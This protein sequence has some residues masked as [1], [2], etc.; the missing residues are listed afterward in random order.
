MTKYYSPSESGFYDSGIH[1]D[2][3]PSDAI[4]ISEEKWRTMLYEMSTGY[5]YELDSSGNLE[6]V[7]G[8]AVTE[9]ELSTLIRNQRDS[10]LASTDYYLMA[11]YP[12]NEGN[13][14]I[15]KAY[16]QSLR[17]IT[18]QEDFPLDISWPQAPD[19]IGSES[20]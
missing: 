17:D 5:A 16:R 14:S 13:L 11:D 20:S 18:L 9:A 15:L 4:E 2:D 19:F 10:L 7:S 12:I 6:S 1:G 3:I 8:Q